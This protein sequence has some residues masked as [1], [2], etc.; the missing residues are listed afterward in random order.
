MSDSVGEQA[1]SADQTSLG[2]TPARPWDEEEPPQ[3]SGTSTWCSSDEVK[4]ILD[5]VRDDARSS[6]PTGPQ[7][8]P[9]SILKNKNSKR[10]GSFFRCCCPCCVRKGGRRKHHAYKVK[11]S[12][13]LPEA[14]P[15]PFVSELPVTLSKGRTITI[16]GDIFPDAVRMSLNLV[17]GSQMDSDLALHLNPRFDQNYVVRNC[18]IASHWG[19]E[20]A[21][22]HRKNPLH[23]GKT[24]ALTVFVAEEQFLVSVDGRHFCGYTFR[25]PLQRVVMLAVHGDLSVSTVEHGTAE[26]YPENCPMMELPLSRTTEDPPMESFIGRLAGP[27]KPGDYVEVLGRVKLLPHSFY[28]N[29][30]HG[31]HIWP[32]PSISLH[33]NPRFKTGA[34]VGVALN[35]WFHHKKRWG[36]E[37]IV[38]STAFRPGREFTLR[39]VQLDDGFQLRVDDKDLTIFK[40]RSELKEEDIV[41][42]VVVQGDVFIH[43]VTVGKS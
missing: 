17:C 18:R 21:A 29:L 40:Y 1:R 39:I 22:A 38:R 9:K 7:T 6:S 2:E 35:S 3:T 19:Q 20:E 11:F 36:R 12:D 14:K 10:G 42:T 5:P 8:Q 34:G 23:R 24:F 30:Q 25:V 32:H 26:I 43:D 31:C 4:N 13:L 15:I 37:E 28:V 33:V 27:L 41:D 16:H